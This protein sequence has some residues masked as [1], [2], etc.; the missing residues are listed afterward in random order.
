[1][2]LPTAGAMV[3]D[4]DFV[5]LVNLGHGA[6]MWRQRGHGGVGSFVLEWHSCIYHHTSPGGVA[7]LIVPMACVDVDKSLFPAKTL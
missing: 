4:Y 6:A 1:M 7:N 2:P 5:R 3:Q